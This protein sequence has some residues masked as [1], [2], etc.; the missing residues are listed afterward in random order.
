MVPLLLSA[1]VFGLD[2]VGED[3]EVVLELLL[4]DLVEEGA[5]RDVS[6]EAGF[7]EVVPALV[8]PTPYSKDNVPMCRVVD[9]RCMRL[10]SLSSD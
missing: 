8:M 5:E 6:V 10:Q 7:F 1:G 9:N 4:E 3:V 2:E